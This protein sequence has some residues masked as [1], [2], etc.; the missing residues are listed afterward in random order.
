MVIIVSMQEI[1]PTVGALKNALSS[2]PGLSRERQGRWT[3]IA[4]TLPDE[5]SMLLTDIV[6]EHPEDMLFLDGNLQQKMEAKNPA[7]WQS[8][9]KKEQALLQTIS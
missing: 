2:V 9:F 8:I 6:R 5:F 1:R 4:S 3:A 7:E